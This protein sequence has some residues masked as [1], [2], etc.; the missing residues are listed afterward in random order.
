MA[1]QS[2]FHI[3][4]KIVFITIVLLALSWLFHP[5]SNSL[6]A[7][8]SSS[9][10][11]N[12]LVPAEEIPI[13]TVTKRISETEISLDS[14][15]LIEVVLE[16]VGQRDA[17]DI[18]IEEPTFYNGTFILIGANEYSF[19]RIA[20]NETRVFAFSLQPLI[21]GYYEIENSRVTYE[22]ETG[23]TFQAFSNSLELSVV[24]QQSTKEEEAFEWYHVLSIACVVWI[25][26]LLLRG[27]LVRRTAN[28]QK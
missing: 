9:T 26:L 17:V 25:I 23:F 18:I 14:V 7:A 19:N 5:P 12:S 16:N 21:L 24:E 15:V 8:L 3:P 11:S 1:G 10:A 28:K 20:V 2:S 4:R 6:G 13:L 27:V 22:D